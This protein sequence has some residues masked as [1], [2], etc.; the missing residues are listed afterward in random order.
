M[1]IAR[2]GL[3]GCSGVFPMTPYA[4]AR[5]AYKRGK[6]EHPCKPPFRLARRQFLSTVLEN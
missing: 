2:R 6:G 1:R 5:D 4:R 3:Q